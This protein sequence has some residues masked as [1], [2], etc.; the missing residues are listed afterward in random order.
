[1]ENYFLSAFCSKQLTKVNYAATARRLDY[2]IDYSRN[3]GN[4]L[5]VNGPILTGNTGHSKQNWVIGK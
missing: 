1:M 4:S 3:P 2:S 5:Y